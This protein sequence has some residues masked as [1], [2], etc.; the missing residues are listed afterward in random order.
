MIPSMSRAKGHPSGRIKG[1]IIREF[2]CWYEEYVGRSTFVGRFEGPHNILD[3][4]SKAGGIL[5]SKWYDAPDIHRLLDVLVDV[6]SAR[7][8]P[9]LIRE[10]TRA[11][12]SKTFGTLHRALIRGVG[13]PF[14]HSRFAQVLWSANYD[15]GE[16]QSERIGKLEQRVTITDWPSHHPVLCLI[17]REIDSVLFPIM[18][19][20]DVEV[21][22][23]SCVSEDAPACAHSI[24]WSA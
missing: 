3:S 8:L 20:R 11:A 6:H 23:V 22:G 7:E 9:E 2:V 21:R 18:G 1:A 13:N 10:G 24:S 14:L 5:A 19:L 4:D 12:A 17:T 15:T 16:L